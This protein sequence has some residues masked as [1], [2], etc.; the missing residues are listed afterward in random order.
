MKILNVNMSLD[1]VLGGGTAERTIQI[2]KELA[3]SGAKVVIL[4]IDMGL[5]E[6]YKN[7]TDGIEIVILPCLMKR[8]Y[9][10][11]FSY[12]LIKELV[13][14]SDIVH[15]MGH[16]TFI[17]ALVYY[18]ARQVKKSYVVCPAG[19]LPIYGRSYIIKSLYNFIVGKNIIRNASACIAI[20]ANEEAHFN[21]YGVKAGKVTFIPNGI[22][23]DDFKPGNGS[24][25]RK[26]Y[27]LGYHS[28]I[29]FMGRL[30]SI[31]GPDLLLKAFCGIKEVHDGRHLV[32]AGPDG[33]MLSELR[34]MVAQFSLQDKV[35][36]LGYLGREDKKA[37]YQETELLV[38]P[39]RQEAMSIVVLEAGISGKPVLITDQCG[40][41][42]IATAN[43]GIVVSA[44]VDGIQK[45]LIRILRDDEMR[46]SMGQ[47]LKRY[48]ENNFTWKIAKDKYL[49]LY[50]TMLI[51]GE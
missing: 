24:A 46:R 16:W 33:G 14:N 32:F 37:A 18:A 3:R 29:L 13:L 36:F 43:G 10:P 45:G 44:S 41:N 2:S 17:N 15:L 31:K 11:K 47:S 8:F 7:N 34:N 4:T 22:N 23:C 19:A 28:F 50:N 1:P 48:I 39:S 35:H 6:E 38:I 21:S 26:K 25:F 49:Q 42:D 30:N 5:P 20:A 12:R 9:F 40:F 27:N 51:S